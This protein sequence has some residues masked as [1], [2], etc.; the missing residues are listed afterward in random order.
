MDT[1]RSRNWWSDV[2][3]EGTRCALGS[4]SLMLLAGALAALAPACTFVIGERPE[5]AKEDAAADADEGGG[6]DDDASSPADAASADAA[7]DAAALDGTLDAESDA[8]ATSDAS[9]ADA[10]NGGDANDAS[11]DATM[12]TDGGDAAGDADSAQD[13]SIPVPDATPP[14]CDAGPVT[15]Y[16]D[17]DND[18]YGRS[19]ESVVA[20]PK[21][22]GNWSTSGGDCRDGDPAVHPN[23]KQ[24]FDT[25]YVISSGK[26]SFDYDCSGVEEGNPAQRVLPDSC[27]G[28]LD[29]ALCGGEGYAA[30]TERMAAGQNP[31]CGNKAYTTCEVRLLACKDSTSVLTEGYG[32]R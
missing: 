29:I 31:V 16:P 2:Q 32:C 11:M 8:G 6:E 4:G 28:L 30:R 9:A 25:A 15:W 5:R 23:Q 21:P 22:A 17:G 24:Y 3:P 14:N 12:F 26:D 7:N 19:G 18:G 27:A 13:T 20:C 1:R 10:G